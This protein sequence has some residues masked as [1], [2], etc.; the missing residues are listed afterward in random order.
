MYLAGTLGLN[1]KTI[2]EGLKVPG[3]V[4]KQSILYWCKINTKS[5]RYGPGD[6]AIYPGFIH[7]SYNVDGKEYT[8]SRLVS[9]Y[10]RCPVKDETITVY[11]DK[12]NPEKYALDI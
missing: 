12:N 3:K 10:A 9:P 4:T 2:A 11:Y 6:G 5:V 1:K 8:G 7:F